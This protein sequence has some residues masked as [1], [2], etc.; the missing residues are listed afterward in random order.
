MH[1]DSTRIGLV[2]PGGAALGA[3]EAGVVD[4]LV[5]DVAAALGAP[6]PLD[7]LCGTSVGAI[8][9]A[10]LAAFADAPAVAADR[11]LAMWTSLR[12]DRFLRADV[13]GRLHDFVSGRRARPAGGRTGGLLRAREIERLIGA[14]IPFARIGENLRRRHFAALGVSATHVA[15]GSTVVFVQT[16]GPFSGFPRDR[17]VA[18]QPA[19]IGVEHLLASSA[20]P[21]LFPAVRIDGALYCEGGL[22]QNVPLA[23]ALHLGADRLLVVTP[24]H[25]APA[26]ERLARAR[27]HAV[28]GPMFLLGRMLN[29]LL[30]DRVDADVDRL[31]QVNELLRAGTRS[32]GPRFCAT[33]AG[34]RD[35]LPPRVVQ[36]LVVRASQPIGRLA[37]ELVRSRR[38]AGR[39]LIG[40]LLRSI[41]AA[42]GTPEADLTA[43]LL[44]DGDFAAELIALGRNDARAHHEAL[45]ALVEPRLAR[46][47][48]LEAGSWRR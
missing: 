9:T 30:L 41:A 13:L 47:P 14:A 5:R 25:L 37:G 17:H 44:F 18:A 3:Y 40:R 15:S 33:L 8:G 36:S 23:P 6:I 43:Y 22:R 42:E 35:G 7:V 26:D 29:A 19:R 2:L 34:A 21:L 45:C 24:H 32:Y 27:E 48:P 28:S 12:A 46:R 39:G 10:L 4:Y 38:F 16:G 11:L 20:I 1:R 31:E